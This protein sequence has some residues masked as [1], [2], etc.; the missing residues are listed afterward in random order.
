LG[1]PENVT[2]CKRHGGIVVFRLYVD[3]VEH[4][5]DAVADDRRHCGEALLKVLAVHVGHPGPDGNGL[6]FRAEEVDRLAKLIRI[7]SETLWH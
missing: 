1:Q 6:D 5:L 2:S 4:E 3:P 7:W